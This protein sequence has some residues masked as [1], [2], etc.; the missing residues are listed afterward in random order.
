MVN[1]SS[2]REIV[3][4]AYLQQ[5]KQKVIKVEELLDWI[6]AK[7]KMSGFVTYRGGEQVWD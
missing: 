3:E 5:N 7:V 1:P 2:G 4:S 6:K